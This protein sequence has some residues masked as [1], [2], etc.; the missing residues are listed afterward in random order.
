MPIIPNYTAPR[1]S[2]R[3]RSRLVSGSRCLPI[4]ATDLFS[5]TGLRGNPNLPDLT[6]RIAA[7]TELVEQYLNRII[8]SQI[9]DMYVDDI[10]T[11]YPSVF[12][13]D[14]MPIDSP[15][16]DYA[17]N[18]VRS[19][20][21]NVLGIY[22]TDDF[23][24]ETAIDPSLYFVSKTADPGRIALTPGSYWPYHR[25]VEGF[26]VR[27]GAGYVV[28]FK[29]SQGVLTA[30]SNPFLGGEFVRIT[31]GLND[32][33]PNQIEDRVEYQVTNVQGNDLQ[34]LDA[35][36]NLMEQVDTSQLGNY[37]FLGAIPE[38]I[39]REI[40]LMASG[41]DERSEKAP[42]KAG[43]SRSVIEFLDGYEE[44]LKYYRLISI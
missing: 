2:L 33:L 23:G 16:R 38:P 22:A 21:I 40:A 26:R 19:P 10:G 11:T 9:W 13:S 15:F 25:P 5:N 6:E 27:F 44:R 28:P 8:V 36:G 1:V 20:A 24:A 37:S 31:K 7:A 34:L 18:L 29:A 12:F 30:P 17:L 39:R 42:A 41:Q 43:K 4:P 35:D 14:S 3:R 32:G